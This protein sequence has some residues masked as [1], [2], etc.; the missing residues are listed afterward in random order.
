MKQNIVADD[1]EISG[2]LR[3]LYEDMYLDR[4]DDEDT[5]SYSFRYSLLKKWWKLNYT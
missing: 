1:S 2:M 4:L 3:E 5:I